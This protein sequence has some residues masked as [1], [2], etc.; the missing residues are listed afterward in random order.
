MRASNEQRR[1]ML[2]L[3]EQWHQSGISQKDFYHQHNIPAHV[4]YY[5]HKC[6]RKQRSALNKSI[7]S[8]SFIKLEPSPA[9]LVGNIELQLCNGNRL[10]F[11]Q[12]VSVEYLKALIL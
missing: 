10:I 8:N 12:P 7:P 11:N 5:W 4:F 1:A 3:I 9:P 6:Y 2:E